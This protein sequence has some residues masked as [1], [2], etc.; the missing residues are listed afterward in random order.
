M[1]KAKI[2]S[3]NVPS[4]LNTGSFS[5]FRNT[6]NVF[7][8][9]KEEQLSRM[10]GFRQAKS[11]HTQEIIPVHPVRQMIDEPYTGK[12]NHVTEEQ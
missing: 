5:K 1:A 6:P 7:R 2:T 8:K 4:E 11:K 3:N 12:R 9:T 10:K